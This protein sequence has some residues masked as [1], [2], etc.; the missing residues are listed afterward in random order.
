MSDSFRRLHSEDCRLGADRELA[1]FHDKEHQS[2]IKDGRDMAMP[3]DTFL[4]QTYLFLGFGDKEVAVGHARD[5]YNAVEA[6][7]YGEFMQMLKM[8]TT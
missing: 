6:P 1:E 5:W 7:R 8:T 3:L 2:D 4:H